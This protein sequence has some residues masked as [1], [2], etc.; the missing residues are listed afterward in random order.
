M[1]NRKCNEFRDDVSDGVC[2]HT[3]NF[4]G[5]KLSKVYAGRAI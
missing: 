5:M 1:G 2:L 4:E 3:G